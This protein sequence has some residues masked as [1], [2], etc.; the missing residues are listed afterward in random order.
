MDE[1]KPHDLA[2]DNTPPER[3][4]HGM[5]AAQAAP[6]ERCWPGYAPG[7]TLARYWREVERIQCLHFVVEG[8]DEAPPDAQS[9]APGR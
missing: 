5:Y 6:P 2:V 9:P 8:E 1:P 7:A 4:V 3:L